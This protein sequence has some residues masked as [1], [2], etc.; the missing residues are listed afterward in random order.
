MFCVCVCVCVPFNVTL[1][2]LA[3]GERVGRNSA[4]HES[5]GIIYTFCNSEGK[6][7]HLRVERASE[8][9][10]RTHEVHTARYVHLQTCRIS[11]PLMRT[12]AGTRQGRRAWGSC[13][14]AGRDETS[15]YIL[16]FYFI[17]ATV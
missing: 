12:Y 2:W 17:F 9:K 10:G 3:V 7:G 14:P 1:L 6:V 5:A 16:N 15:M 4:A 8:P 11:H 13:R